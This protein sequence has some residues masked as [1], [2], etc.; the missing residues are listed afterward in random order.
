MYF[1]PVNLAEVGFDRDNDK[2]RYGDLINIYSQTGEEHFPDLSDIEL[3]IIGVKEDRG[4]PDNKGCAEAPDLV[5]R[6]LYRL[7]P[8]NKKIKIADLG[9]IINGFEINDTYFALRTVLCELI[10]K[11]I[12]PI[13]IGGSQ[14]LTLPNYQAYESLSKI[15]NI[16]QVDSLFDL[17]DADIKSEKPVDSHSYISRIITLKPNFLFTFTNIGYQTYFVSQNEMDLMK[18]LYFDIYRLGLVRS[19]LKET[20]PIIRNADIL[21][22]DLSSIRQSDAPGNA[23]ATPNGFLGE[24]ACQLVRYAG[25]SDKLSSIG[26]YE[27]NPGFDNN[28]QTVHLTAQ[29]IW[30]FIDGF[31]NRQNEL[32][33]R[34]KENFIKLVVTIQDNTHDII[35]YKSKKT[36]KWWMEIPC[37]NELK[38]KFEQHYLLPC[39][40]KD[41]QD[42]C[43]D[44]IPDRWWQAYQ[45]M[46]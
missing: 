43:N 31:C 35:F 44:D 20:E 38:E 10:R 39:S 22:F 37:P 34:N 18:S 19:D 23:N 4:A 36:E 45:K 9:N 32:P 13:I 8:G 26:F 42:A 21:S 40:V 28:Y 6:Y 41:Y 14:D 1:E 33:Y 30:Y 46:M 5:R 2:L 17:G 11:G 3:V 7:M 24:E 29:M 27:I 16:V 25:L 12:I 15:V